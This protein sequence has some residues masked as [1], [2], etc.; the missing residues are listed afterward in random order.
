MEL[1]LDLRWPWV[2]PVVLGAVLLVCLVS[3]WRGRVRR[4]ADALLVAR[5]EQ[6][7]RLPRF[8][9][10][11]RRRRTG[12]LLAAVC[13]LLVVAGA[14]LAVAR[15]QQTLVEEPEPADRDVVLCLDGAEVM[16]A[17]NVRAVRAILELLDDL[18]GD[19][20][21]LV[22]WARRTVE[23]LGFT[24]DYDRV[25][26]ELVRATTAF[27]GRPEGW[28]A[29]IGLRDRRATAVGDGIVGCVDTYQGSPGRR[30]RAVLLSTDNVERPEGRRTLTEAAAYAVRR[31]V[32]VFALGGDRLARPEHQ[33]ARVAL[34]EASVA[35][36]GVLA[37][38]GSGGAADAMLARISVFGDGGGGRPP[39]AVLRDVPGP[40][41]A[42]AGGGVVGLFALWLTTAGTPRR[43]EAG[44]GS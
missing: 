17:D 5:A 30:P 36:G 6:V 2:L 41:A 29:E 19:R 3:L 16:D 13:A 31:E 27:A 11:A 8:R 26:E 21:A 20:V 12:G 15:P 18:D 37:L 43:R 7:R 1:S 9:E 44:G 24:D 28:F 22:L 40:A 25:R 10:L 39:R 32:Q 23:V 42:L 33:D 14:G 4:G 38:V 34:A 35:T